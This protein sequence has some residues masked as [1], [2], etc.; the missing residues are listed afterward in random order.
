MTDLFIR[1]KDL[2]P[3]RVKLDKVRTTF[4]GPEWKRGLEMMREVRAR[5]SMDRVI[6]DYLSF[7]EELH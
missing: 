6:D 2:K 5:T 1:Q 4:R 3:Y 7:F